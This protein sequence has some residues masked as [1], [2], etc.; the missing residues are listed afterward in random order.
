MAIYVSPAQRRRK[1]GLIA[2]AALVIGL[3]VGGVIGTWGQESVADQVA[4]VRSE[5][6]QT[7]AGL[8]VLALH[9]QAQVGGT[10]D[11]GPLLKKT[12]SEVASELAD[13]PW[14]SD[15]TR[16]ALQ[17]EVDRLSLDSATFGADVT[18]TADDIDKAF[19]VS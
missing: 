16:S 11:V 13:A 18:R 3:G 4:H 17:A 14:L 10:A 12:R 1:T 2:L 5:A 6:R 19:G 9:A 8:R 7:S 15:A